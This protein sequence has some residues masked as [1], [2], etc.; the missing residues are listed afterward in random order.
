MKHPFLTG[1][2][3][4]KEKVIVGVLHLSDPFWGTESYLAA[5]GLNG[6]AEQSSALIQTAALSEYHKK[7]KE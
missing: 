3:L 4:P 2:P 6:A 1:A 5:G 7:D